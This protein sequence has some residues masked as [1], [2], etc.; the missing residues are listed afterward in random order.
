MVLYRQETV[1]AGR[2]IGLH[3]L[4][5]SVGGLYRIELGLVC[6][7]HPYDP[8]RYAPRRSAIQVER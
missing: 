2:N 3:R 7:N 8:S 4:V 1:G 6:N 5:E